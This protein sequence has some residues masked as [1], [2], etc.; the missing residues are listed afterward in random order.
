LFRHF[1]EPELQLYNS[2]G[3]SQSCKSRE[4]R[5]IDELHEG[6]QMPSMRWIRSES[7]EQSDF[8]ALLLISVQV[9]LTWILFFAWKMHLSVATGDAISFDFLL[10]KDLVEQHGDW[11]RFSYR[12]GWLGGVPLLESVGLPW[13]YEWIG[14]LGLRPYAGLNLAVFFT[15]ILYAFLGLKLAE[16]FQV[17][18]GQR[19]FRIPLL[20]RLLIAWILA[21]APAIAWKI[22]KGHWLMVLATLIYLAA[23]SL[24]LG[25]RARRLSFVL[26]IVCSLIAWSSSQSILQQPVLNAIIFGAPLVL[27][28]LT[29]STSEKKQ[30]LLLCLCFLLG[31]WALAMNRFGPLLSNLIAGDSSRALGGDSIAFSYLTAN[32]RDWLSSLPWGLNVISSARDSQ[33]WH[34]TNYPLGP[35]LLILPLLPGKKCKW[36]LLGLCVSTVLA[37]LFSM[38]FKP[39][40]ETLLAIVPPLKSFRV[41]SRAILPAAM[42]LPILAISGIIYR[43]PRFEIR[44]G[45]IARL[46]LLAVLLFLIRDPGLREVLILSAVAVLVLQYFAPP[47]FSKA[48]ASIFSAEGGLLL[49]GCGSLL[50][51]QERIR[52]PLPDLALVLQETSVIEAQVMALAPSLASPL[53]RAWLEVPYW[54]LSPNLAPFIHVSTIL[55]YGFPTARYSLLIQSLAGIRVPVLFNIDRELVRSSAPVLENLYDVRYRV[56]SSSR[57]FPP[58]LTLTPTGGTWGPA[59]FSS[60]IVGVNTFPELASR[61]KESAA[62]GA[63][64]P[65]SREL[66][67]VSDREVPNDLASRTLSGLCGSSSVTSVDYRREEQVLGVRV[68]T[69][70]D[71]P[72]T[73]STNYVNHLIAETGPPGFERLETFPAYGALLGIWV[74]AHTRDIRIRA[75]VSFPAWIRLSQ[76]LGALLLALGLVAIKNQK[77]L[78]R[79]EG[80]G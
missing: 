60:E 61:L 26:G 68:G 66:V 74:P 40:S 58:H 25:Y 42:I 59:W 78:A 49:L 51:F 44:Q 36:L 43:L 15:Q 34:E 47:L 55:G 10:L 27:P 28:L 33:L 67:V 63:S 41:P 2:Q 38:D 14:R 7:A 73:I 45:A 72:L 23:A 46:P 37:I 11:T 12:P 76:A 53:T 20:Q 16:F 75:P 9:V 62:A 80:H 30:M 70:A 18:W 5:P 21:F 19:D 50:A 54:K 32:A 79:G 57:E 69:A 29:G 35:L 39:V 22:S 24:I 1:L 48:G 3:R 17:I 13:I 65:K 31:G 4:R 64:R 8:F 6:C 52:K 56:S 71:C 77:R